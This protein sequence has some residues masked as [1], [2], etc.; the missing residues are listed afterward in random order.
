MSGY[1]ALV[2]DCSSLTAV[3]HGSAKTTLERCVGAVALFDRLL[4]LSNVVL[5]LTVSKSLNFGVIPDTGRTTFCRKPKRLPRAFV[6][7]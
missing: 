6:V 1:L 2:F 5:L 3:T 7:A 4:S